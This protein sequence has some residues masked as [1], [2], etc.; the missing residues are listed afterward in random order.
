MFEII[1]KKKI[2]NKNRDENRPQ[3]NLVQV[4][5]ITAFHVYLAHWAQFIHLT[6]GVT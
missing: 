2:Y 4:P 1:F 5:Y 6:Q 3:A